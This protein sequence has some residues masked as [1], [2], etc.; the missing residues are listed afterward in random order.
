V[1]SV[2]KPVG[3]QVSDNLSPVPNAAGKPNRPMADGRCPFSAKDL[4]AARFE[5]LLGDGVEDKAARAL[6]AGLD[7]AARQQRAASSFQ[8]REENR[9]D[10]P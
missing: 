4:A 10:D 3:W 5:T 1:A 8:V 7:P 2:L 6:G 9:R